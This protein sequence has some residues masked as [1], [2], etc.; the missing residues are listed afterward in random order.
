MQVILLAF[1]QLTYTY[2]H[3][4]L[5]FVFTSVYGC[6]YAVRFATIYSTHWCQMYMMIFVCIWCV[7]S[8]MSCQFAAQPAVVCDLIWYKN[9]ITVRCVKKGEIITLIYCNELTTHICRITCSVIVTVVHFG[10]IF[11]ILEYIICWLIFAENVVSWLEMPYWWLFVPKEH[12]Q[13]CLCALIFYFN[14]LLLF[15]M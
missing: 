15:K 14:I 9:M 2:F 5:V 3:I 1:V 7:M 12:N 4:C 11:V 10:V 6:L 13:R 8:F